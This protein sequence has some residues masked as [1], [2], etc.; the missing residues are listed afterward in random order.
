M[1]DEYPPFRL[2]TGG[3]GEP[4]S[5]NPDQAEAEGAGEGRGQ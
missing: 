3:H 5:G 4:V 2:D 1:T